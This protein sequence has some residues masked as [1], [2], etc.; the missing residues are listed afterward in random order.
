MQETFLQRQRRVKGTRSDF[1]Q[2]GSGPQ[3]ATDAPSLWAGSENGGQPNKA[4]TSW[5]GQRPA[6][7]QPGPGY[8]AGPTAA[9]GANNPNPNYTVANFQNSMQTRYGRQAT[10]QEMQEIGNGI[11][12][13]AQGYYTQA[14]WDQAQQRAEAIARR[15]GWSG[16]AYVPGGT[17]GPVDGIPGGPG[18]GNPG[19]GEPGHP[20]RVAVEPGDPIYAETGQ[21][22]PALTAL[23][24]R[25]LA[26]PES[27]SPELVAQLK[28]RAKESAMSMADQLRAS[29]QAGVADRGF[30][31]GGGMQ[32]G[33]D[34]QVNSAM[35]DSIINSNREVDIGAASTNFADRLAALQ[36][37][38]G[39][40]NDAETRAGMADDRRI[41]NADFRYGQMRD[42]RNAN[43]QEFL[44]REGVRLDNAR[45]TEDG[46]QFNTAF[47]LDILRFL[48][49]QRQHNNNTGLGWAGLQQN[50][51]DS[52]AAWLARTYRM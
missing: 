19:P 37:G 18:P 15:Q 36:A 41:R 14:Q 46:R 17:S 6:P 12:P 21:V 5:G 24:E 8:Q 44:G 16:Q 1:H 28:A 27:M 26:N 39:F 47:G 40:L 32:A 13:D 49:S 34:A 29:G 22:N 31:S 45:L 25:V 11:S 10:A 50:A 43:L 51:Q 48:E 9:G 52:L 33:V 3:N 20:G 38:S 30:G 23:M 42:D 4:P 7:T 35:L 2:A